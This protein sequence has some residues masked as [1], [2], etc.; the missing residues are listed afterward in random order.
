MSFFPALESGSTIALQI[1]NNNWFSLQ[2]TLTG[3]HPCPTQCFDGCWTLC[4]GEV[5][6][7]YRI[8]GSGNVHSGDTVGIYYP[9]E[10]NWFTTFDGQGH[11]SVCPGNPNIKTGF[12]QH[13]LW[14]ICPGAVFQVFATG[15]NNGEQIMEKDRVAIYYPANLSHVRFSATGATLSQCMREKSSNSIMPS[16]KAF[17]E[18]EQDSLWL[19]VR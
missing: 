10:N 19:A 11:K 9:P 2:P 4:Y 12:N 17:D 5:F 15:K 13:H 7:I 6:Q 1:Y 8:E 16:D 3:S 14:Y 18:C